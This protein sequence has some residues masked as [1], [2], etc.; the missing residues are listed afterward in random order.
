MLYRFLA[1]I[2][3]TDKILIGV[4]AHPLRILQKHLSLVITVMMVAR[5]DKSMSYRTISFTVVC[6]IL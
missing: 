5:Y 2:T 6:A 4:L 1:Y 3:E